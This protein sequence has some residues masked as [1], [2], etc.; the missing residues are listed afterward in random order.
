MDAQ[1]SDVSGPVD[2]L[3]LEFPPGHQNF[4]GEVLAEIDR[5]TESGIIRVLDS[6]V[7]AKS[8]E[9][10][11]EG[12]E[13]SDLDEA[14][15]TDVLAS[16]IVPL[17]AESDV[18]ALA[19][20]MEPGSVAG[21]LVYENVWAA[22]FAIAARAAG[23]ELIADGRIHTQVLAAALEEAAAASAAAVEPEGGAAAEKKEV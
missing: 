3:V 7:M 16:E 18:V 8:E 15:G 4:T 2:F 14:E 21:V 11:V 9:G 19:E 23:A 17:I 5:L 22:D 6:I 12:F 20:A 10:E 13:L 1:I